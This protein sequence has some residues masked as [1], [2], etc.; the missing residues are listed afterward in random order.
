M[1][2]SAR[3]AAGAIYFDDKPKM[4][5]VL[6]R[7][8]SSSASAFIFLLPRE[9]IGT[10]ETLAAIQLRKAIRVGFLLRLLACDKR[11]LV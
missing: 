6:V 8:V 11:M 5:R 2:Y 3:R 7:A 1:G 9:R 4:I 10:R